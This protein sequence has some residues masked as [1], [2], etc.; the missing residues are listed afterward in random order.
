MA[1]RRKCNGCKEIRSV[2]SPNKFYETYQQWLCISCFNKNEK[3]ANN[4]K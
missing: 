1:I 3:E 2:N 4:G